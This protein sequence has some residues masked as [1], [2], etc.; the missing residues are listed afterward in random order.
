MVERCRS[1]L[2]RPRPVWG[3]VATGHANVVQKGDAGWG[4]IPS[5]DEVEGAIM[6]CLIAG[7]TGILLFPQNFADGKPAPV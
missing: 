6:S 3:V 2:T 1:F 7:A 5:A 4:S